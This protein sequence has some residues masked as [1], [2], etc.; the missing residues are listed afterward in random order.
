[1]KRLV[2]LICSACL[3]AATAHASSKVELDDPNIDL[4]DQA[5]LQNGAK[6][7]VNYCFGCHSLQYQRYESL[8]DDLGITEKQLEANFLFGSK[9]PTDQM[10]NSMPAGNAENWFGAPPPDLSVIARSRG[11]DWLYTFLRSFYLD[12]SR[13]LGVNNLVFEK[14]GMP[15]QLW[16]LQG[17]QKLVETTTTDDAGHEHTSH[18]LELVEAGEMTPAEYDQAV[19]EL[20]TFLTYV[21]EPVKLERQRLGIFVLL[22]LAVFAVIAYILKKE[23]WRDVH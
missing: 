1:M 2:F 6:Y 13:P 8:V 21:G 10:T 3:L 17:W 15:H 9:T 4:T 20:V 12:E 5:A 7:F 14:V 23:F 19:R 16:E 18:E 11:P 22:F